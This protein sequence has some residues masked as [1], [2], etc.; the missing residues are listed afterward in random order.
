MDL[1]QKEYGAD[2]IDI[3]TAMFRHMKAHSD[4]ASRLKPILWNGK[5]IWRIF[6][7]AVPKKGRL[8]L[9]FLSKPTEP[10]QGVDVRVEGGAVILQDGERVQTLRTWHEEKYE[11]VVEYPYDSKMGLLKVWNVCH[12][13]WPSGEITEEARRGNAGILVEQE[14]EDRWLFRCN[15]G[16]SKPP[17]FDQLVFRLSILEGSRPSSR[18]GAVK[19]PVGAP[20]GQGSGTI[21]TMAGGG[22]DVTGPSA[23]APTERLRDA[24]GSFVSDPANPPS[25]C[26]FTDAQRRAEWKRLAN[27]PNSRLTEV[28]RAEVRARGYASPQ[29]ANIYGELETMELSHEP[30]PLREGGRRLCLDCQQNMGM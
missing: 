17:D 19:G 6:D 27:D 4:P 15:N 23:S 18:R 20:G 26:R 25:P 13:V 5:A 29:R 12:W 24:Q 30:I 10:S 2:G 22:T 14:A 3:E 9:E 16:P 7:V 21:A 28:E 11:E 1:D 8:R